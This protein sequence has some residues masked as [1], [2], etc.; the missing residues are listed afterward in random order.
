MLDNWRFFKALARNRRET[1][2]IAPSGRFLARRMVEQ[3]GELTPGEV[4]VELGPGT[5]P[6]TRHLL[7]R[8]PDHPLV[9]IEF[10]PELSGLLR[11]RYPAA[12]VV[13]G[14]ASRID[15]ALAEHGYTPDQVGGIVSG[16]P[17]LSLPN[18]LRDSIFASIRDHLRPGRRYVQ[19]TYSGLAWRDIHPSGF[20]RCGRHRVLVNLPPAVVITFERD[21]TRPEAW[22]DREPATTAEAANA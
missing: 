22:V 2:A 20:A 12:K 10:C 17:M 5:G 11:R 19:F 6:F 8:Y 15:T 21:P 9:A 3:L 7:R 14:C 16:L 1:G 13:N 4:I 18:E